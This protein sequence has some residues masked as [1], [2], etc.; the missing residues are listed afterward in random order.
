MAGSFDARDRAVL[1]LKPIA[2]HKPGD[3]PEFELMG[4][5]P[6]LSTLPGSN[7]VLCSFQRISSTSAKEREQV[8]DSLEKLL[9]AIF[10]DDVDGRPRESLVRPTGS[11]WGPMRVGWPTA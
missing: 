11:H 10:P 9:M 5:A 4:E 8:L 2:S 3:Q 7:A 6:A 1:T